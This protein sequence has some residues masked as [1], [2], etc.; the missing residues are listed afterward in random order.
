MWAGNIGHDGRCLW[1]QRVYHELPESLIAHTHHIEDAKG[2]S[3]F[4]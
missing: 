4:C 2:N 3:G 1:F